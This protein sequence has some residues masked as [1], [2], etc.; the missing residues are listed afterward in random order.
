MMPVSPRHLLY[1]KVGAK[2]KGR[3]AFSY[4]QTRLVQRLLVERAYR[5][6]FARDPA[7]W[8][9]EVKPREVNEELFL[10]E[11]NAWSRWGADQAQAEA[12]IA[13]DAPKAR[14]VPEDCFPP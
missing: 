10:A 3:F 13:S 7:S 2:S 14:P 4:E 1:V 6:V 8:V 12:Q 9:A 11:Q 5:W